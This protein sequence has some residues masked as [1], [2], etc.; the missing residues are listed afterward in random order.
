MRASTNAGC[1]ARAISVRNARPLLF[2]PNREGFRRNGTRAQELF[3]HAGSGE[4]I[5]RRERAFG[6]R[7][8]KRASSRD[9]RWRQIIPRDQGERRRNW[10]C[11][12]IARRLISISHLASR[13][14]KRYDKSCL[15]VS[16]TTFRVTRFLS[17]LGDNVVT[18]V[19]RSLDR[20]AYVRVYVC[21]GA[22]TVGELDSELEGK[23]RPRTNLLQFTAS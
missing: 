10:T 21:K 19:G 6:C 5:R 16:S 1:H 13:T 12:R 22:Y 17:A 3:R 7:A 8:D 18:T 2:P 4:R 11:T 23:S 20:C 14:G 9:E 15:R